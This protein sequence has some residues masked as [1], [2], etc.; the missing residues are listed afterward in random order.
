MEGVK[1]FVIESWNHPAFGP[2]YPM[3][4]GPFP[5]ADEKKVMD[6]IVKNFD[7]QVKWIKYK[8]SEKIHD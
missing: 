5:V 4:W 8:I 1:E 7:A 6:R 3:L 2:N